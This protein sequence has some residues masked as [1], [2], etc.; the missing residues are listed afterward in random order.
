MVVGFGGRDGNL[1]LQHSG[2]RPVAAQVLDFEVGNIIIFDY[3]TYFGSLVDPK[4]PM[5]PT[6]LK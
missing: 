1:N 3:V 2:H 4:F 5:R 6:S